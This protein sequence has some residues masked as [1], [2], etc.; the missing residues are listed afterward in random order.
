M[1]NTKDLVTNIQYIAR[2]PIYKIEKAFSADFVPATGDAPMN[3]IFD[4]RRMLISDIVS[5]DHFDIDI[6][7]FCVLKAETNLSAESAL[8]N[9][10]TIEKDYFNEI[11]AL[12]HSKFPEYKRIETMN[13]IVCDHFL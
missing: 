5:P 2:D 6:H 8:L 10:A 4:L 7:G 3:H 11:E 9:Q 1:E 12:L 13:F